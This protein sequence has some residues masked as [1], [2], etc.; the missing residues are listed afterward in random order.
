MNDRRVT[1]A[2]KCPD[3]GRF[4]AYERRSSAASGHPPLWQFYCPDCGKQFYLDDLSKFCVD[5]GRRLHE[6]NHIGIGLCGSCKIKRWSPEKRAAINK[7]IGMAFKE[8]KPTDAEKD[9]AIDDAI[10]HLD[11]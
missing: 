10:K 3:C 2:I 8:P 1:D 4:D 9:A 5:C 6:L 7:I 11:G